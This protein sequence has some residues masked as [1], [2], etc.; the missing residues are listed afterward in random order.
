MIGRNLLEQNDIS[1]LRAGAGEEL[2]DEIAV[3]EE[4]ARATFGIGRHECIG[5]QCSKL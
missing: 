1:W 3:L 4:G 5:A 2:P